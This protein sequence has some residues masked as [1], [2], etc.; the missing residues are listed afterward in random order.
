MN[1]INCFVVVRLPSRPEPRIYPR[2]PHHHDFQ[3]RPELSGSRH[4]PISPPIS[5][6]SPPLSPRQIFSPRQ[7][8][9]FRI[10]GV[11]SSENRAYVH[12]NRINQ[13]HMHL[14]RVYGPFR[15]DSIFDVF[16]TSE[17]EF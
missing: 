3:S 1:N 15:L 11:F 12:L 8:V 14:Y 9:N 13:R 16:D 4:P 6:P 5:P 17:R 7:N 2:Y 10:I